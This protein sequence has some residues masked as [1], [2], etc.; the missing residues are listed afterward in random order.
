MVRLL[1]S[2]FSYSNGFDRNSKYNAVGSSEEAD[3]Y[4]FKPD[5]NGQ[6]SFRIFFKFQIV[7]VGGPCELL[8]YYYFLHFSFLLLRS[9][10]CF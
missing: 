1:A 9:L 7:Q 5:R 6:M 8:L 10:R 3:D 2:K 4:L